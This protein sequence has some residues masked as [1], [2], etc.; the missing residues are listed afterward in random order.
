MGHRVAIIQFYFC[1]VPSQGDREYNGKLYVSVRTCV[2]MLRPVYLC[3]CHFYCHFS[4]TVMRKICFTI[5]T[6]THPYY[7]RPRDI[8][9]SSDLCWP[10][11]Q[12]VISNSYC[13]W[14]KSE[15]IKQIIINFLYCAH[16]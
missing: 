7:L 5:S 10:D 15:F 6:V 11:R 9:H 13:T 2:V 4:I 1:R 8:S 16:N 3:Q 14:T 12:V